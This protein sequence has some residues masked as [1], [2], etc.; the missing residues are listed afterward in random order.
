MIK[1]AIGLVSCAATLGAGNKENH[2]PPVGPKAPLPLIDDV[3]VLSVQPVR[4]DV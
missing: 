2:G 4:N 1:A 3:L